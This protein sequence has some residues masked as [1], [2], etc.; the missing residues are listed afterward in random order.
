MS[1]R[2]VELS[3][4]RV[5]CQDC[6]LSEL[7][8]PRTLNVDEIDRLDAIVRRGRLLD[9]GQL[10]FDAGDAFDSLYVVRSGSLKS[11]MTTPDGREQIVG[12]HLP[13][14]LVGLD[15]FSTGV[16]HCFA[17]G[18][19]TTSVCG[20]PTD[21]IEELSHEVPGLD[22]ALH[23]LLG[24]EIAEDQA[25]LLLLGKG[26]AE[27]R[28]A[29]FLLSLSRRHAER[30]FSPTRFNLSMSRHEIGNYLGLALETVSRQFAKLQSAGVLRVNRRAVE[31]RALDALRR[32]V[33]ECPAP[34]GVPAAAPG[35]N[36]A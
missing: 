19:E 3:K 9:R 5:S 27:E 14:E 28:L 22:R 26:T 7:C 15:G 8:L 2:T 18:L 25:L 13:G 10:V 6:S 32:L 4:L 21:R 30:G 31:I 17:Q 11:S 36:R 12:F 35:A 29:A 34:I 24:R 33:G 16:H 20:L 23:R 1:R